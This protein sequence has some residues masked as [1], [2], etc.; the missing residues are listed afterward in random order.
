MAPAAGIRSQRSHRGLEPIKLAICTLSLLVCGLHVAQKSVGAESA[1][2][3]SQSEKLAISNLEEQWANALSNANV[4]E[5]DN[6]LAN[7]FSRPDPD[8]GQFIAKSALLAYYRTHLSQQS[9]RIRHIEEMTV[10]TYGAT[11][12]ARGVVVISSSDGHVISKLLFTDVFVKR[13]NRWQAVSA[14]ENRVLRQ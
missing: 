9:P 4:D 3:G 10:S 12:I 7:D 13:Q 1:H 14:Q 6:I 5:I 11:A 2:R 8:G